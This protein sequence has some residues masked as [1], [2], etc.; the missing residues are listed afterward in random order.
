MTP[1]GATTSLAPASSAQGRTP[2]P[3]GAETTP[4]L[5]EPSPGALAGADPLS[6][7][8]LFESSDRQLG[9]DEGAKKIAALQTERHQALDQEQQAIQQ[10]INASKQQSFWDTLGSI[11]G[12]VAKVAA[13]VASVAAAVA[14]L[15]AATPVAAVAI[16]G[17]VL[18]SA[19]FAES[20]FHVLHALG[21]DDKTVGWVDLGMSL[22]GAALSVGAGIVAG[23]R[24]ASSLPS[25]IGRAG[26][27]VAGAGEMG[28]GACGI[29]AGQ[30][31]ARNDQAEADQVAALARSDQAARQMRAAIVETQTSDQ[32]S[33]QIMETIANTKTVQD[34]TSLG[35]AIAVRG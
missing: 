20:E 24:L 27:V 1:I 13:V 10:A 14:T 33:E 26:A 15:G 19:S 12:E 2:S 8:Y 17:A 35:A 31:K 6:M 30:A 25:L 18:S 29:E 34:E 7:L 32:Q 28:K 5:P 11:C 4:L 3:G 22:G 23:G 21:V 9:V 16:A